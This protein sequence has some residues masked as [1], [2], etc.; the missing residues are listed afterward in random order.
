MEIR[1][2]QSKRDYR[3]IYSAAFLA[4]VVAIVLATLQW[5][6][7]LPFGLIGVAAAF[8]PKKYRK[9]LWLALVAFALTR[10]GAVWNGTKILA[11]RLFWLSEQAQSYEYSYFIVQGESCVEAVVFLSLLAGMIN[12]PA[13]LAGLWVV[14]MAYFGITPDWA[15]LALLLLAGLIS[16]LPRQHRWF[17]GLIVGILVL[18]IAFA[19]ATIAPEPSKAI[20]ELDEQL[21]D[22]LAI[23]AVTYEQEPIPTEVPEPEIV[24]QPETQLQ[25]PDHGVQQKMINILFMILAALTLAL[26]FIP[27]VIK[28]RAEKKSE[29]ARAGFEDPDHTAAIKAMYLYAQRWRKLSDSPME[30]PAEVKSIWQEAAYSD[31]AMTVEQREIVRNYMAETAHAVWNASDKKKQLHIRYRICL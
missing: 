30:I 21:R 8:V 16:T 23:G 29:Q 14:A 20:S 24:P 9:F 22:R 4:A 5:L 18:A 17:Y 15:W 11:N 28:D 13:V 2:T 6:H 3:K 31:H 19:T 25:Q 10:L 12:C 7:L 26:L 27:A 1:F